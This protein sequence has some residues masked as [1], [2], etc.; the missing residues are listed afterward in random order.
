MSPL[1]LVRYLN[2]FFFQLNEIFE[3]AINPVMQ[4][5][6]FCC[7]QKHT[8]SPQTLVCSGQ[9]VCSIPRDAKY[10]YYENKNPAGHPLSPSLFNER[11]LFCDK[12]FGDIPGDTVALGDDPSQ[13]QT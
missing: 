2:L 12:C 7:G 6:G 5:L 4:S 11:Y 10:F 8:F 3:D 9:P 1:L 13:P